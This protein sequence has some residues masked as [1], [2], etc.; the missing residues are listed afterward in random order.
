MPPSPIQST[1]IG[2]VIDVKVIPSARRSEIVGLLGDAIKI[3]VAAPRE[4]GKA[5]AAAC[6]LIADALGVPPRDVSVAA[7]TSQPNKRIAVVGVTAGLARQSL[8]I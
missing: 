6:R 5:N 1:D 2:I 4:A 7:G 3:K 8:S